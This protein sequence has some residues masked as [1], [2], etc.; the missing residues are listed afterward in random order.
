MRCQAVVRGGLVNSVGRLA[1]LTE[2]EKMSRASGIDVVI[3]D[4]NVLVTFIVR[5]IFAALAFSD[6]IIVLA[7][8]ASVKSHV[9]RRRCVTP[10]Q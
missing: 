9:M 1:T 10:L 2:L 4:V 3:L 7:I 8:K 5:L 6:G